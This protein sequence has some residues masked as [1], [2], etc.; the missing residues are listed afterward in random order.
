MFGRSEAGEGTLPA[1]QAGD[2]RLSRSLSQPQRFIDSP[3][4]ASYI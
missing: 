2:R 3:L 1:G 4:Q